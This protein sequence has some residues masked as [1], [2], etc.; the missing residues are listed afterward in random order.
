MTEQKPL[1]NSFHPVSHPADMVGVEVT[2]FDENENAI[3]VDARPLRSLLDPARITRT[4]S[5]EKS[6]VF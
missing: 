3:K 1:R 6:S 2:V 5:R 4:L